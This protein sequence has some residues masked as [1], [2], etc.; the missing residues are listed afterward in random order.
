MRHPRPEDLKSKLYVPVIDSPV[1][2]E[3]Q[4]H[5][6][7]PTAELI[8]SAVTENPELDISVA[9]NTILT[10]LLAKTFTP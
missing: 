1:I 10:T 9:F 6:Y 3:T 2:M 7:E 8:K 4:T 5:R